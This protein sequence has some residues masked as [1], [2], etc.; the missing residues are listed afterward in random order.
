MEVFEPKPEWKQLQQVVDGESELDQETIN[1]MARI[2]VSRDDYLRNHL[3]ALI[4]QLSILYTEGRSL[5]EP[6]SAT[7]PLFQI[8][9][10][11]QLAKIPFDT[12]TAALQGLFPAEKVLGTDA[13]GKLVWRNPES[14]SGGG[15]T[16]TPADITGLTKG[17][18]YLE[19]SFPRGGQGGSGIIARNDAS[20]ESEFFPSPWNVVKSWGERMVDNF[21]GFDVNSGNIST[22]QPNDQGQLARNNSA[23]FFTLRKGNYLV[24][25]MVNCMFTRVGQCRFTKPSIGFA[26]LESSLSTPEKNRDSVY[27]SHG[28]ANRLAMPSIDRNVNPAGNTWNPGDEPVGTDSWRD[29]SNSESIIQG[30][31]TEDFFEGKESIMVDFEVCF[32]GS[33]DKGYRDGNGNP[34]D[35]TPIVW[36][37]GINEFPQDTVN[38]Y[39]RLRLQKIG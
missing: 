14:S 21:Y 16:T 29:I 23:F 20:R 10:I 38:V 12:G 19:E 26:D 39:K 5:D 34:A 24:D 8:S 33:A 22:V 35:F 15:D 4:R 13:E 32:F 1:Q 25:A 6:D 31:I 27:G 36:G 7:N 37:V 18:L 30:V 3:E 2:I 11:A 9:P 28:W 17:V